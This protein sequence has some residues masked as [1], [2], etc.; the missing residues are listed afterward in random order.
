MEKIASCQISFTP[1][2]SKNYIDDVD[3]VLEIIKDYDLECKIGILS[4]TVRGN[5]DKIFSMIREIY[6]TMDNTTSF[7]VDIKISNICGCNI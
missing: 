1:I 2:M 6:D 7:V 3:K 5:K 4:T